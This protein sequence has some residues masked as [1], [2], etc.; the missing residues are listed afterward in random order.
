MDLL[1]TLV[2][3]LHFAA[4]V[5][6]AGS[7]GFLAL[8]GEPAF[9]QS[10]GAPAGAQHFR[11][12]IAQLAGAGLVLALASGLLWLQVEASSMSGQ[13]LAAALRQDIVMTVLTRTKFGHDWL[14]RLALGVLLA[15]LLLRRGRGG[16]AFRW[17][18]LAL[19]GACLGTLAWAGHAGATPGEAGALH[20]AADLLH[21]LAAGAWI[22]GLLPLAML[23]AAA[24][25]DPAWL[26][27]ART[28]TRR[29]SVLGIA[30][31]G[32]L[33]ATGIVNSWFLVGSIPAL[34][35]TPYGQLLL[36]KI[37]LFALMVTVAAI[38]RQRLT[39]RLLAMAAPIPALRALRRN[40][41]VET[42][43]G[44]AI[45][46]VVGA[47]G[48]LPPAAHTQPLWPFPFRLDLDAVPP[49]P[50]LDRLALLSGAGA[51]LGLVLLLAAALRRR[52]R[53]IAAAVGLALLVGFGRL[54]LSWA[55]VAAYP[56]SFYHSTVAYTAPSLVRGATLYQANCVLCHGADGRGNGPAAHDLAKKPADL[57]A[58]HLFAHSSGDLFWW[59]SEGRGGMMPGFADI[60][61]ESGRWDTINFIRARAAA[62]QPAALR[63]EVTAGPAPLAPDFAFEQGNRQETLAEA[64]KAGP[65]LLVFY[66]LP[67]S[68]PR[69]KE[70]AE[71]EP[72]LRSAGLRLIA[73][74]TATS[75]TESAAPLPDFAAA[76]GPETAAAYALFAGPKPGNPVEFLIGRAGFLRARWRADAAPG[77]AAPKELLAQLDRLAR[78]PLTAAAAP[79]VHA[80]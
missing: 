14:L 39:P 78:L 16:A 4:L 54:P 57:T 72:A 42:A 11:R 55:L 21:L 68:G 45:L 80:H 29:F 35:G 60:M 74:P 58:P 1:T 75:A 18:V 2:R 50:S 30:S 66:D 22:G 41:L 31:I 24:L 63:P 12:R 33:L 10:G 61:S 8:I 13:P 51:G 27:A 77:L 49:E 28:A 73:L 52:G 65:V 70:L 15:A 38:N 26:A 40:A 67:G 56:T 62:A 71:A 9:K 36:L 5:S 7:V 48:T 20:L 19:G 43:L 64:R 6:V 23:F 46:L 59:I 17:L 76:T 44:L 53:W 69:L 79:H 47:L 37:A 25:A 32:A 34:F 3:A